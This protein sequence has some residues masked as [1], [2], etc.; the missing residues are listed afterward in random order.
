MV[1]SLSENLEGW[2]TTLPFSM[3]WDDD[4]SP[5][6][7]IN[8][9]RLRAK[10]YGC[11]YITYRPI[12]HAVMH[13]IS[14]PGSKQR[15]PESPS[16]AP[17]SGSQQASPAI[18]QLQHPGMPRRSSEMGPPLR[19]SQAAGFGQT[20]SPFEMLEPRFQEACRACVEAAIRSTTAFDGL[21]HRLVVT[22]SFGTMHA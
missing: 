9:A 1:Q 6:G 21:S 5:A 16:I 2:R 7:D 13:G 22:N 3:R 19:G 11:R 15:L 20:S 14:L 17:G 4:D 12:L 18:S 10:Y 8:A